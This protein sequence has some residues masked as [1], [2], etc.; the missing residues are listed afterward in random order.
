VQTKA[1]YSTNYT[2]HTLTLYSTVTNFYDSSDDGNYT[3]Y[4]GL[5]YKVVDAQGWEKRS[6]DARERLIKSTR[7]LNINNTDYTTAYTYDD[8]DNVTTTT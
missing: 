1:I 8:G 3:V 6:Y 4:P 2:T 5:L 7:H